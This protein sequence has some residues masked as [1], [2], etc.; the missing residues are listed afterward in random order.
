MPAC[1]FLQTIQ[2]VPVKLLCSTDTY[3]DPGQV[4][5]YSSISS[6]QLLMFCGVL[7]LVFV[8]MSHSGH[9][10]NNSHRLRCSYLASIFGRLSGST[11]SQDHYLPTCHTLEHLS[12]S[13]CQLLM[14]YRVPGSVPV[15]LSPSGA[16]QPWYLPTCHTL[17]YATIK[18]CQLAGFY[19]IPASVPVKLTSSL[20]QDQSTCQLV[21]SH[22]PLGRQLLDTKRRRACM[23][24]GTSSAIIFVA[25]QGVGPDNL[26]SLCGTDCSSCEI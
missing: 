16:S 10:N 1:C 12:I 23:R 14:F 5:Q 19:S 24:N 20:Q 26:N 15:N 8:N 4:E 6:C 17:L 21:T 22:N 13:T 11:A 7:G 3:I 18:T 2:L 25:G 9:L